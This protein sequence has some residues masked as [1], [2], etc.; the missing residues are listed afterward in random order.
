MQALMHEIYTIKPSGY[1]YILVDT[2]FEQPFKPY[3]K[4]GTV[5]I[6][7]RLIRKM[8]RLFNE[9]HFAED[10]FLTSGMAVD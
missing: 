10:L 9:E 1:M 4:V 3:L 2:D 5:L 8:S 6:G 7:I